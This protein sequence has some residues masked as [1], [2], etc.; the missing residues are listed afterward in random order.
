MF[1][2]SVNTEAA[3]GTYTFE[4]IS[5]VQRHQL[6]TFYPGGWTWI[7]ILSV[8]LRYCGIY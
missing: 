2:R 8:L 1:C 5:D 4:C 6:P 3:Y 7:N